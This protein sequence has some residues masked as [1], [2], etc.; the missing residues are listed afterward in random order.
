MVILNA[1]WSVHTWKHDIDKYRTWRSCI[2][3][4][5][6][7]Y[8]GVDDHILNFF[9]QANRITTYDDFFEKLLPNTIWDDKKI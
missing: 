5:P 6:S 8:V 1:S 2:A 7:F 3:N 4:F 9:N